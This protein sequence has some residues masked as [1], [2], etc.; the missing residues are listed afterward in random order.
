MHTDTKCTHTQTHISVDIG[1]YCDH[2]GFDDEQGD[3]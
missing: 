3:D 1:L 2:I